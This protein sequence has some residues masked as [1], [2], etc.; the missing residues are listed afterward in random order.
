MGGKLSFYTR[1]TSIV[2]QGLVLIYPLATS[3]Y[4]SHHAC[5]SA[6]L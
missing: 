6:D 5:R 2:L 1:S 4:K 3:C